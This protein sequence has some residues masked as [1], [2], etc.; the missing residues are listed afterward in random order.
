MPGTNCISQAKTV[1]VL[2]PLPLSGAYDYLM[3]AGMDLAVGD[4][5][6]VPL[7]GRYEL[8][9]VWGEGSGGLDPSRLKSVAAKFDVPPLPDAV[10]RFVDWAANYTL[11]PPGAVLKM[12]MSVPAA[13]EPPGTVSRYRLG[14]KLPPRPT[15]G[16][17]KV[18]ELLS[19]DVARSVGEICD[20]SEVGEGV[21]RGLISQECLILVKEAEPPLNFA[22]NPDAPGPLLSPAQAEAAEMLRTEKNFSVVLLDGVT[23]SGKTEVYFEA[24]AEAMRQGRQ[25]LVLL[26]EIAL[27]AQW[28]ARFAERFGAPPAIWHSDLGQALRRRTWRA[29]A[30]GHARV[31]VGARSALFLPFAE[32]GLIIVDEEHDGGYKQDDG[33]AY[34]ARDMAVVRGKL[35]DCL[36]V[37]ASATPSIETL[38]N[39]KAGR[40]HEV[41]LPDRH[42]GALM[43][44]IRVIDMRKTPPQRRRWLAPPLVE[45]LRETLAKGEQSML[46]LN[47]RGYAPLTLCR[48]C[49]YRL[50]CPHCTAWLVEH[51]SQNRL[52]CHHCGHFANL[53]R[54]CPECQNED[55][56]VACGPGV[57][58][59]A[60]EVSMLFPEARMAV[61]A[62]DTIT[63]P[64]A[65][66]ELVRQV[67]ERE[68]DIL[69]GTQI[70]AKGHH[71]PL[72]TL[73]GV[74][75]ADLGLA[76]GDLRA[77]ERTFQMLS[78]VAGRAG[79]GER[80][81]VVM[82]QSFDPYHPVLQ[83]IA[84]Q[85]RDGFIA[86]EAE[87][88]Q[89]SMMPPYGRLAALI[90]SGPKPG[91]VADTAAGLA[92]SAPVGEGIEVLGPAPAPLAILR[93]RHRQRFL[94]KTRRDLPLQNILRE[95]LA[96]NRPKGATRI[97]VDI[98]PYS[99]F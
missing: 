74:V 34:N 65:A 21:V 12:A 25:A 79:R 59:V 64:K 28:L 97:Q 98:D 29:V 55:S 76:G 33:V 68:I 1:A 31:V 92:K 18:L 43:P 7:S 50:Q 10:R 13:L 90:V 8:G 5:V 58:R 56:F 95:W 73:V 94:I 60:E 24:V 30:E 39:V 22:C 32:L 89:A 70:M 23:G 2:L 61:M 49:G 88:R 45:A 19:D 16:R 47:R 96:K 27:S 52:I 84:A 72:L 99:F 17:R 81:G 93:G 85:D 82:L 20:A 63:S 48:S 53:P 87:A 54:L 66:A 4:F 62:S 38:A 57:E 11:S 44:E 71:F 51:R 78:Q 14:E 91:E 37:L 69:V 80:S 40:Y 6:R 86:A 41:H 9:V 75:D 67:S 83:A 3:P 42:A 36:V 77:A 35:S 46:F 26:P 15:E